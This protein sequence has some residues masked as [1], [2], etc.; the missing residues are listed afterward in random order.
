MSRSTLTIPIDDECGGCIV[1]THEDDDRQP[2]SI[3]ITQY[4]NTV[5]ITLE[6]TQLMA[7]VDYLQGIQPYTA[8][9]RIVWDEESGFC[10]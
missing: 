3:D 10:K 4:N 7:L 9:R 5:G 1:V 2:L 8:P 6:K